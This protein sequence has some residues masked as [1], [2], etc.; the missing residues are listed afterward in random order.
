MEQFR[1]PYAL[2]G[3]MRGVHYLLGDK[4]KYKMIVLRHMGLEGAEHPA[5][6]CTTELVYKW[7]STAYRP[8]D[9]GC[10]S[11]M[12]GI[13]MPDENLLQFAGEGR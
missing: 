6:T 5:S 12:R 9:A 7:C 11:W 10:P 3:V 2:G 1:C 13:V 4:K 8:S